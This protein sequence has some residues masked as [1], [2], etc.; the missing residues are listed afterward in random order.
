MCLV[1]ALIAVPLARLRP[2]QGR[3]ARVWVALLIFLLYS[4]LISV[5]KVLIARGTLPQF[6]GLWWTHAV[7]VLLALLVIFGTGRSRT[8]CVTGW[9]GR[10]HPRPLHRAHHPRL[11]ADGGGRAAGARG[12]IILIGEQDDIG[13]GGYTA[14]WSA[15]W[16][17]LLNLPHRLPSTCCRSPRSWARCIGLGS[18]AR[19]SE[20]TVIRATGIS[21]AHL[22]GICLLA[23][24]VLVGVRGVARGVPRSAAATDGARAEGFQPL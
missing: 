24:L 23:G 15:L 10:E 7:V 4:Q 8:A 19:G 1:L 9:Q 3:Y 18:L 5:G 16:F 11:R 14:P 21:I 22:A 6:L 2:R 13:S 17:T 20:L 12:A